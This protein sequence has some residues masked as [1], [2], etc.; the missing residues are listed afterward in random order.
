MKKLRLIRAQLKL[1][2]R[3]TIKGKYLADYSNDI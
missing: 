3:F 2:T 1:K